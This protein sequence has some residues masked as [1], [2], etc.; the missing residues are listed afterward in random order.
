MD[1]VDRIGGVETDENDRPKEHVRLI[2][3][4]IIE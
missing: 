3:A 1:V 4:L 2:E